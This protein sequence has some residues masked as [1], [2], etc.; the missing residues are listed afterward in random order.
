MASRHHLSDCEKDMVASV[1]SF[2]EEENQLGR[3]LSVRNVRRRTSLACG[4]SES[5]V[6]RCCRRSLGESYYRAMDNV[7]NNEE[8]RGR[9]KIVM[10]DFLLSAIR[11]E[12]HGFFRRKEVPT[13]DKVLQKCKEN[14][15]D[16]PDIS[17]T[18][19]RKCMRA[20]GFHY[21]R[22]QGKMKV[23]MERPDIVVW[24]HEFL[25]N[26][27]EYR[28][29]GRPFAWLDETWV[30]AH[31]TVH[32]K[33]Y[34]TTQSTDGEQ[35]QEA[36]SGKGQ[37]LIILHAGTTKGFLPDC[38]LVFVGKTK[39]Y[40]YHDEMNALH[41]EEW[42][43][44]QLLP[45]LPAGAVIVMDNAPYHTVKTDATTCPTSS[46]TKADMQEW[47]TERDIAWTRDMLKAELYQLVK[48]HKPAPTY[49]CDQL[50][51]EQGFDVLRL[52]PY[53]CVFNPIELIWAWIKGE[54]GKRN[55]AFKMADVKT[56]MHD[57]FSEVTAE[58]W[59]NVAGHCN[60]LIEDA[61]END[62][63]QEETLEPLVITLA[64][65]SSSSDFE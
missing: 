36:P 5:T 40:D 24:R 18:T 53:H 37:R 30:N 28:K 46:S 4:V 3:R 11:L 63:L 35:P 21:K 43:S 47:L 38:E 2:F 50:A 39:S 1:H 65:D 20:M 32:H 56:L 51:A 12:F 27:R 9:P 48:I 55:T 31:H 15:G 22:T 60:Q 6:T 59:A 14:I 45:N 58:Q 19:F 44:H 26:F 54:V 49:V 8:N 17:K 41:F 61:W 64:N 33:W 13:I 62:C 7:E 25:R 52:P 34:D 16:F 29:Q 23:M 57:V 42:W 10:D